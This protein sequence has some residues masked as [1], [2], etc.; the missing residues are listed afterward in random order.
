MAP[1]ESVVDVLHREADLLNLAGSEG[2][3]LF[4]AAAKLSPEGFAAHQLLIS[5]HGERRST[6]IG[7]PLVS[8]VWL[9]LIQFGI[10]WRIYVDQLHIPVGIGACGRNE[11]AR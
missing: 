1:A 2:F 5:T 6:H 7:W 10:V 11:K 8:V 3:W 4:E 9:N